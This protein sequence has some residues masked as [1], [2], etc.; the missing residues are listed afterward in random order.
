MHVLWSLPKAVPAL[1][2]H[3]TAY[4]E[5]AAWD[6]AQARRRLAARLIAFLIVAACLFFAVLMG[7]IAVLALTWD[8]PH[9]VSAI[10]WMGGGF[11]ALAVIALI[12]RSSLARASEPFLGSVREEWRKDA[13]IFEKIL[14]DDEEAG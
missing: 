12:Y 7:C 8:G 6:L 14:A 10:A 9:R 2:R 1:L 5:L 3:L 13:V 4:V 11:L